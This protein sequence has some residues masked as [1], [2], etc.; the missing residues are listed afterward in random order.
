M[1]GCQTLNNDRKVVGG[2]GR[3]DRMDKCT[4]VGKK[5]TVVGNLK[6]QLS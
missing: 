1:R 5:Q 4:E 3:G 2:A 6:V